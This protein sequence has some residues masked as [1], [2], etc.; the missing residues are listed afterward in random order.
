MRENTENRRKPTITIAQGDHNRLRR[1]ASA[2]ADRMPEVADELL[3]EL[4]RAKV[5]ADTAVPADVARMG[6]TVEFKPD[7]GPAKTV[8]LVFPEE[9]NIA[10]GKVSILTPIGTALIGLKPGQSITWLARDG[11]PHQLTILSVGKRDFV[12]DHAE[13]GSASEAPARV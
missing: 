9:A 4:D 3:S 13:S 10:E 1:L 5:V 8:S 6:S 7:T 12:A 2:A 11:R